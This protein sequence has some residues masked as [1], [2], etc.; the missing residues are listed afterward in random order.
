MSVIVVDIN[1]FTYDV[2]V[3]K[4]DDTGKTSQIGA[5]NLENMGTSLINLCYNHNV[6]D[7]KI[8]G[9]NSQAQAIVDEIIDINHKQNYSKNINIEVI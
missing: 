5:I 6:Y 3:Y 4:L 1:K 8:S 7:I 2:P 9:N